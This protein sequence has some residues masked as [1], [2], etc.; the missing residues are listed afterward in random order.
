MIISVDDIVSM[1]EFKGKDIAQ[2]ISMPKSKKVFNL[3]ITP[4]VDD[5]TFE[6]VYA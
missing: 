3:K 1:P 5:L 2:F 4:D 6:F